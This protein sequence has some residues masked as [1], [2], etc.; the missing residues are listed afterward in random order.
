MQLGGGAAPSNQRLSREDRKEHVKGTRVRQSS[1]T[2]V[3]SVAAARLHVGLAP[4]GEGKP[5][6]VLEGE[7]YDTN[8]HTSSSRGRLWNF[9][10]KT[11]K[12]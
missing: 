4:W 8:V 11:T 1:V 6:D 12:A 7:H 3:Q 2:L 10:G 9:K 5:L